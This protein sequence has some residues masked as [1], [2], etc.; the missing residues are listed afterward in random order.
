MECSEVYRGRE[1]E[2]IDLFTATFTAS[3]GTEE[4]ALIGG[5]VRDLMAR[6]PERDLRVVVA[7]EDGGLVGAV[8]STRL[9]FDED[10]RTVFVLGPVAVATARQRQGI[11][12]RMLVHALGRLRDSGVDVAVTYGDPDYYA[13]VG[14]RPMTEIFA[15]APFRLQHPEGWLG[16]SLTDAE[17]TPLKGRSRCVDAL[18]DPV[19]W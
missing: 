10:N 15:A 19:F 7:E 5:L 13:K 2:I 1:E 14:F 6:T 4:G 8:L 9:A 16:R 3:E 18:N 12:Q 11:G 17:M